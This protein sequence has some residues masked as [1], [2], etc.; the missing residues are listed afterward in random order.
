MCQKYPSGNS[1]I[2]GWWGDRD[3]RQGPPIESNRDRPGKGSRGS[4]GGQEDMKSVAQA[5]AF[6]SF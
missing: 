6:V 2:I 4:Q 1:M 5:H 3:G